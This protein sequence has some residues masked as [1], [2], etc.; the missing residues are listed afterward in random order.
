M[1]LT[2]LL[3]SLPLVPFC[4][5]AWTGYAA[6]AVADGVEVFEEFSKGGADRLSAEAAYTAHKEVIDTRARYATAW[7][8]RLLC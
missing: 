7:F 5:L 4:F 6:L 8:C 1:G 2:L 3:P